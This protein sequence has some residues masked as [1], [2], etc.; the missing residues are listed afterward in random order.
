VNTAA[1]A[2]SRLSMRRDTENANKNDIVSQ[3]AIQGI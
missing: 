3:L 2:V 1:I